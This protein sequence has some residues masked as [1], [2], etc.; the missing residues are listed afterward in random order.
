MPAA[1]RTGKTV[2]ILLV[3]D[4]PVVRE[5][6]T[7]I[8][9]HESDLVVCGEAD[10]RYK[11]LEVIGKQ[12]PDLVII[13]LTLKNSNGLELIKD[14]RV[15]WPRTL[16]LVVS[17]HDESLYAERVLHAGAQGYITKQEATEDI[18]RA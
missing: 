10:D 16:I 1:P 15:G 12:R 9:S 8:F 2:R 13:D 14:I 18:L 5:R 3:D 4:H 6:M 11:A 17:M 7:E